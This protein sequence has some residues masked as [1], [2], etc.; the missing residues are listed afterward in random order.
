MKVSSKNLEVM[1]LFG[2]IFCGVSVGLL[3]SSDMSINMAA[4]GIVGAN[5]ESRFSA[6]VVAA[7]ITI[8]LVALGSFSVIIKNSAAQLG[9]WIVVLIASAFSAA[10]TVQAVSVDYAINDKG[11]DVYSKRQ[12][13]NERMIAMWEDQIYSLQTKMDACH[14]YERYKNCQGVDAKIFRLSNK[15][16]DARNENNISEQSKTVDITDAIEEK[17]G[18]SGELVEKILIF[19]RAIC[20]PI[21]ISMLTYGFWRFFE[22]YRQQ[23]RKRTGNSGNNG[24][25]SFP[26]GDS[27]NESVLNGSGGREVDHQKRTRVRTLIYEYQSKNGSLPS[28]TDTQK[29]YKSKYGE[30]VGRDMIKE[31]RD[32]IK[33]A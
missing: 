30:G 28:Y 2:M 5:S 26:D 14:R 27:R 17:S 7:G 10:L 33:A 18:L 9:I 22:L 4:S 1:A 6:K 19:S 13:G 24:A 20:V 32:Q 12:D 8:A 31:V 15:I 23:N 3:I 25:K 11:G 29:L 16:E 21:M